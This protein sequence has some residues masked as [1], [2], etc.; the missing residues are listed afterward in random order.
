MQKKLIK[1]HP[2][3]NV[4]VALMNVAKGDIIS[5]ENQYVEAT[6]DVKA[7]HKLALESFAIGDKIFMYG[8]LVGKA[9][10]PIQKGEVLTIENVKHES[11]KVS[12]KTATTGWTPPNVD[13]W[14]DKTF[15]GYHRED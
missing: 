4:A 9:S 1:V 10:K 15:M 6:T 2:L 14:I 3:D 8:V 12:K 7:K 5:F 13:K 11:A